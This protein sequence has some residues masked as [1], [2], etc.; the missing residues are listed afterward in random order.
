MTETAY[1]G[2]EGNGTRSSAYA[3]W[4]I[5]LELVGDNDYHDVYED[6]PDEQELADYIE[7]ATTELVFM[8]DPDQE[9]LTSQ[10]A[11]AFLDDVNWEEIAESILADWDD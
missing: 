2:W 11:A 3:T 8:D 4:R 7:E 1:N 6:K 9:K 5:N 10:Y